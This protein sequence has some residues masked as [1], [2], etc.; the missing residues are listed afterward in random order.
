M[1]AALMPRG[2]ALVRGTSFAAP[3][4]GGLLAQALRSPDRAAAD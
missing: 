4:V 1:T 2:Y 3:L